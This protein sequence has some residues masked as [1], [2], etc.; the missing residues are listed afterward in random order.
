VRRWLA[1]VNPAAGVARANRRLVRRLALHWGAQFEIAATAR[2]GDGARLAREASCYE[3]LLAVGGDGTIAE[4]LSGME[5]P[6]QSLALLPAGHGNCLAR[7]L[8]IGSP[9]SAFAALGR[10]GLTSLDL[11][12]LHI[13][14]SDG[15]CERRLAAS[16]VAVGYVAEVVALGRRRFAA[17][18]GFAYTASALLTCTRARDLRLGE[19]SALT[20]RRLTNLVINNTAH[21]A[22]FRAFHD[23]RLDDGRLDVLEARHGWGRQMLHNAAILAGSRRFGPM[24][25]WQARA[26]SIEN[27]RPARLMVDGELLEEVVRVTLEC[28]PGALRWRGAT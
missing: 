8:G 27:A 23:A 2:P 1:I 21:L 24:A 12:R 13:E 4:V 6:R 19:G 26:V 16:T 18:G 22:N 17:L 9:E 3:G 7:D 14:F 28:L 25:L 15:R 5:L 20:P 11:M 10:D